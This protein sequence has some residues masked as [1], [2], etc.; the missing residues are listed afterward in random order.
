ML[1]INL[2]Y[3]NV[4]NF[5]YLLLETKVVFIVSLILCYLVDAFD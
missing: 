4:V 3:V 1:F 5:E 2:I